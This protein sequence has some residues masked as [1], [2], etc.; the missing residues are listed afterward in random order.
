MKYA[1]VFHETPH[2]SALGRSRSGWI[3]EFFS[4]LLLVQIDRRGCSCNRQEDGKGC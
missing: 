1:T 4:W 2:I 3:D